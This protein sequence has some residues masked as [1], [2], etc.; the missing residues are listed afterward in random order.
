VRMGLTCGK[1]IDGDTSAQVPVDGSSITAVP[2]KFRAVGTYPLRAYA[3]LRRREQRCQNGR[4]LRQ[5]AGTT[6][7]RRK[8]RWRLASNRG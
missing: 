8:C 6:F 3:Q 5:M 7:Q 2:R 4:R 1:R